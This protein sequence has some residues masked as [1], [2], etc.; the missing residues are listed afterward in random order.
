MF[1]E[2]DVV[3]EDDSGDDDER[4]HL[5]KMGAQLHA[6]RWESMLDDATG[7]GV[8]DADRDEVDSAQLPE[9]ASHDAAGGVFRACGEV[10]GAAK[11]ERRGMVRHVY[12]VVDMTTAS[13]QPD[14]KPRRL[15]F[16]VDAAG[17]FADRFF[18]ENP[19]AEL[20]FV[21][22]R[23]GTCEATGPP[24]RSRDE[25]VGRLLAAAR[26]GPSGRL[27]I[28]NGLSRIASL[29]ENSP[30]YSTREALVLFASLSTCDPAATSMDN[31][32]VSLVEKRV[33]VSVVSMSPEVHAVRKICEVTGGSY[34]V[35][36]NPAHFE[37]LLAAHVAAPACDARLVVPRLIRMGFPKQVS[38]ECTCGTPFADR[39]PACR[40]CG[41]RRPQ[42]AAALGLCAC[43]SRPRGRL[44][45]CPQCDTRV[46]QVPGRCPSCNLTLASAPL[47]QRAF[48]QLVPVPAFENLAHPSP[49]QQTCGGCQVRGHLGRRC[50]RCR[51]PFCKGC[52]DFVHGVLWQCPGCAEL[53][54]VL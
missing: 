15:E 49:T 29:L 7:D 20:G 33:R 21:A 50:P 24:C 42:T 23:N 26:D 4:A 11:V 16:M 46:C 40:K 41:R 47:I 38:D 5:R 32:T 30:H 53:P 14:Y 36:L 43:H 35:A 8:V 51:L 34:G 37:E 48:R 10:D 45:C 52:D 39:A 54:D 28:V 2:V 25:L 44:F 3:A 1:E 9:V 22:L 18:D 27:S 31:V 6:R 13:R 19:L 12:L 17:R